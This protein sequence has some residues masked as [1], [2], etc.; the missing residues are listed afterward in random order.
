MLREARVA[1]EHQRGAKD[2]LVAFHPSGPIAVD[3]V[4]W[5][6]GDGV[7]CGFLRDGWEVGRRGAA[8]WWVVEL[9]ACDL[10]AL[11]TLLS[12]LLS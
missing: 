8:G 12:F 7:W 9:T 1:R 3:A 4:L 11:A 5:R 2:A 6:L 10:F